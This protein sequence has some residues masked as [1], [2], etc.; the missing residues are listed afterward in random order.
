M[1]M[2]WLLKLGDLLRSEPVAAQGM[3]QTT[4]ALVCAFGLG[5]TAYQIGAILAFSAAVLTFVTRR[6]VTPN[7]RVAPTPDAAPDATTPQP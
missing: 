6:L 4:L 7:V 2:L 3:M 5:L 1:L